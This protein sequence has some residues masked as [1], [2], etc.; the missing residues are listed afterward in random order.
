MPAFSWASGGTHMGFKRVPYENM[1]RIWAPCGLLT[2]IVGDERR[3]RRKT[4]GRNCDQRI[5]E[6][7]IWQLIGRNYEAELADNDMFSRPCMGHAELH[8]ANQ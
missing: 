5:H 3:E 7:N 4:N 2:G 6:T 8:A 1:D